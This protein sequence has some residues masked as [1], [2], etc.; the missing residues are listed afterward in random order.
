VNFQNQRICGGFSQQKGQYS[1]I[2]QLESIVEQG[3]FPYPVEIG[4]TPLI[5]VAY[6]P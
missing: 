1:T 6:K 5:V 4:K 2:G 3:L